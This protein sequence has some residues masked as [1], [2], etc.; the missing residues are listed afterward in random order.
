MRTDIRGYCQHIDKQQVWQQVV[1]QLPGQQLHALWRQ[2]PHY[3]VENGG[4]FH[5]PTQGIPRGCALSSLI[6]AVLLTP[7]DRAMTQQ[8][9]KEGGYYARY[10]DDILV[11]APKRWPLRRVIATVNHYLAAGGFAQHPDKT[12]IGPLTRG[13]DW[14]GGWF[15]EQG[16]VGIAPVPC[17]AIEPNRCGF[18][19]RRCARANLGK[20]ARAAV[21]GNGVLPIS[22]PQLRLPTVRTTMIKLVLIA[23]VC[24]VCLGARAADDI[25][26]CCVIGVANSN[27]VSLDN[28]P[29]YTASLTP[30]GPEIIPGHLS[31]RWIYGIKLSVADG[32]YRGGF[33]RGGA[34]K[35]ETVAFYDS[36]YNVSIARGAWL[37]KTVEGYDYPGSCS[38]FRAD[39]QASADAFNARGLTVKLNPFIQG[40]TY[41]ISITSGDGTSGMDVWST[42]T[43]RPQP[44]LPVPPASC[45]LGPLGTYDVSNGPATMSTTMSCTSPGALRLSVLDSMGG[46]LTDGTLK[47]GPAGV[48]I[49]MSEASGWPAIVTGSDGATLSLTATPLPTN[50]PGSYRFVGALKVESP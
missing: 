1:S 17:S 40:A 18:M 39:L 11:L 25:T 50:P 15:T 13:F 34:L 23:V 19:S 4:E 16:W 24:F 10:M 38:A 33:S 42:P 2:F 36:Q 26:G 35:P 14:L 29:G 8:M 12:M 9:A 46:S 47:D 30:I 5:T 6:G 28:T 3:S 7:L 44:P 27:C 41:R 37:G 22:F 49:T 20:G 31:Q 48:R 43:V 32:I 21:C 45:S